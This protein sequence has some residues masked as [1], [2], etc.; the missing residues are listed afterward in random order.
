M[1]ANPPNVTFIWQ[2]KHRELTPQQ[3][4]IDH[5]DWNSND[6]S[7]NGLSGSINNQYSSSFKNTNHHQHQQPHQFYQNYQGRIIAKNRIEIRIQST[8]DYGQYQCWSS[9]MAG[10]QLEP[11]LYNIYGT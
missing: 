1:D 4:I 11:C 10:N 7:M 5:N 6:D 9:N 3:P 2:T 8:D